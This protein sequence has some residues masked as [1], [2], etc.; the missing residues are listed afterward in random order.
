MFY[1]GTLSISQ[2]PIY[3][4]HN[5]KTTTNTLRESTQGKHQKR[6]TSQEDTD[7]VKEHINMLP[8]V[9]S[10]YCRKASNKDYLESDMTIKTVYK[11]YLEYANEKEKSQVSFCMYRKIF[12]TSFNIAFHKPRKDR[13]DTCEEMKVKKEESNVKEE[14]EQNYIIIKRKR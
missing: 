8:R 3:T 5:N 7:F 11:M 2:K 9:K 1:T 6:V 4:V 10:H 14:Q 12:C 13:C